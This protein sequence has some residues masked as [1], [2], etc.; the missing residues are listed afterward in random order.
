MTIYK[1][2]CNWNTRRIKKMKQRYLKYKGWALFN[3]SG[4]KKATDPE[5]I[6]SRIN[7]IPP[8]KKDYRKKKR[9]TLRHIIFKLPTAKGKSKEKILQKAKSGE[10]KLSFKGT[11]LRMTLHFVSEPRKIKSTVKCLCFGGEKNQPRILY[12]VKLSRKVKEIQ[13]LWGQK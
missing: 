11:R 2:W 9:T 1:D 10:K 8:Q 3:I 6:P 4:G 13:R 5:R 7:K 12:P